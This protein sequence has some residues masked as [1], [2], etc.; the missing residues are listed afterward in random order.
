MSH[1]GSSE[2]FFTVEVHDKHVGGFHEFFLDAAGRNVDFVFMADTRAS[3]CACD[4]VKLSIKNA[5]IR[6]DCLVLPCYQGVCRT[7]PRV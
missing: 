4:L 3:S 1:L 7:Q 2:I 6:H 5:S